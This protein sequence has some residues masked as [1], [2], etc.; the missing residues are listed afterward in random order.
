MSLRFAVDTGG[1]FTDLLAMGA[2]GSVSMHKVSTTP[3][4]PVAGVIDS[5]RVAAEAAG[6]DLNDYLGEGSVLV[7][8]TTHAINAIVTGRTARTAFLTTRGHP[9]VLVFREGAARNPSTSP[10]PTPSPSCRR[11]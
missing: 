2:D 4:D 8:G 9:D 10:C 1:T 7:H 6:R 5:L 11:P 3:G